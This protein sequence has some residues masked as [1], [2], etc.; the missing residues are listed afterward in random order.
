[1]KEPSQLGYALLGLIRQ[2]PM[3]GY[4]LRKIFTATAMGSFSDSPGAIYPALGRLEAHGLARGIVEETGSLR[5]RRIFAITPEG[6]AVFETWLKMPVT[7]Y[8]VMR[9][10]DDLML[11]FAF[12]D[13]ALGAGYAS[14]FLEQ[15]A[16]QV[17]AYIPSLR[18][19]L[20]DHASEMPLSGR[21]A[22]ECGIAEY[23]VRLKWARASLQLYERRKRNEP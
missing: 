6:L 16:E 14:G 9:R 5:R 12:M 11:R 4:D 15:F 23:E 13:E 20:E 2:Q 7:R 3:S 19:Y 8:D 1:M 10:V 17:A 21:L 18:K 22:L